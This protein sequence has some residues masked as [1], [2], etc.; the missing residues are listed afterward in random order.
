MLAILFWPFNF[1]SYAALMGVL[2]PAG[3]RSKMHVMWNRVFGKTGL[4]IRSH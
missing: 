1:D 3:L 4:G 2:I